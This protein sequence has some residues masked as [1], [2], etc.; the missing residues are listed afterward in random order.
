[1]HAQQQPM[2][3]HVPAK[4][5]FVISFLFLLFSGIFVIFWQQELR[6]LLPTPIPPGYHPVA[7]DQPVDLTG[8]LSEPLS[9]PVLLHFFSA[10]CPCSRFNIDHFR[11][12]VDH[13]RD[14][15]DFYVV[16]PGE[17][18][19]EVIT[20]FQ[21]QYGVSIPVLIDWD[22][23]LAKACGVYSTPQ[24]AVITLQSQLYF[25]GNYNRARYCTD[26]GTSY[27]ELAIK[28]L[29]QGSPPPYFAKLATQSYGC[30]LP[31]QTENFSWF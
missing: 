13:Y 11:Y 21:E 27:A 2:C 20:Q 14:S 22:E 7:T 12:L 29:Y 17:N 28:A 10:D 25:R 1:M 9:K 15:I 26:R 30:Q 3:C 18:T 31:S 23:H 8:Y 4:N 19:Q 16:L 24:A 5:L 6:Y